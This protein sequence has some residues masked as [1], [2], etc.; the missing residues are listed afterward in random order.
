ML[1]KSVAYMFPVTG[2][3]EEIKA[4]FTIQKSLQTEQ[5]TDY[6]DGDNTN[7]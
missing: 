3:P 4:I 2:A 1:I 5:Y 6:M 7:T